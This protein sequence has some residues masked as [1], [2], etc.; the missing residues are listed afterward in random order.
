[1]RTNLLVLVT[2]IIGGL[3]EV[4]LATVSARHFD[5]NWK[6]VLD[7]PEISSWWSGVYKAYLVQ[8]LQPDRT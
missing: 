6:V 5:R 4:S 2:K 3:D 8:L 1:M 7:E